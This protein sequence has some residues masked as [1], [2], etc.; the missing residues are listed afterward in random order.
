[1]QENILFDADKM[2]ESGVGII[3][4]ADLNAS[5]DVFAFYSKALAFPDY[6]GWNWDAFDECITD[7]S[8]LDD[9]TMDII[10]DDIPLGLDL[11]S[12][13]IF[14]RI[15]HETKYY[16]NVNGKFRVHFKMAAKPIVQSILF[17][18]YRERRYLHSNECLEYYH[19][20]SRWNDPAEVALAT[21]DKG[22]AQ[23]Y[24]EEGQ[25]NPEDL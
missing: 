16:S 5:H 14:L 25:L 7:L 8:W 11:H 3:A 10:H 23:F 20:K 2:L 22:L 15:L 1:M 12:R 4:P 13:V 19:R 17:K 18:Y 9:T 21:I 24:M 6:F